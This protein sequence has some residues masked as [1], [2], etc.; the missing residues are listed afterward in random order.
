MNQMG[1][2][3]RQREDDLGVGYG[4]LLLRRALRRVGGKPQSNPPTDGSDR[5]QRHQ[6]EIEPR[7]RE[8]S[9]GVVTSA[10]SAG[11]RAATSS[12][13]AASAAGRCDLLSLRPV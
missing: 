3:A 11:R 13:R 7:E 10:W 12:A 6:P 8:I 4:E 1:H 5:D 9:D 2:T